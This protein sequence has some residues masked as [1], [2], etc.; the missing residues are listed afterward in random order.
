MLAPM[1][2]HEEAILAAAVGKEGAALIRPFLEE[3]RFADG[4]ALLTDGVVSSWLYVLLEGE[5]AIVH[6]SPE[7]RVALGKRPPGCW[8]GEVGV[9]DGGPA[10]ATVLASGPCRLLRIDHASLL[11][12]TD[13]RPD[14]ASV[15]L[16]HIMKQLVERII[17]SSSGIV[18]QVAPGQVFVR[19]PEPPAAARG[20]AASMFGWL[21]GGP[22]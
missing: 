15:L 17:S 22:R 21:T 6:E 14:V 16:R 10:S 18:E 9:I 1:E 12:L 20:W 4:E 8:S 3:V 13:E 2:P 7:G 19:K 11:R 5:L